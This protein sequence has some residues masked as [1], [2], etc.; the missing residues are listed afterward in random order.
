MRQTL[1]SLRARPGFALA[2]VTMLGLGIGIATAMFTIVDAL[3]LRP[4]PFH[5]PQELAFVYMGNA[6]G[7]RTTVAPA[8]LRAWRESP[9]FTGAEGANADTAVID[10][11]G[12]VATRGSARVT[13]GLFS[14][15]GNVRPI[16]GRLFDPGEGRAGSDD[17]VVVSEDLWRSLYGA[18]PGIINQRVTIDNES[19]LVVG[20]LPADF[21]FPN[22][23]TVIWRPIDYDAPPAGREADWPRAYVRFAP[24]LPRDEAIR[25]AATAAHDADAAAAKLV[26]RVSPMAGLRLD[27]YS[28]RAV[29]L[30]A[31]AVALVFLVLC[32]NVCSLLLS[33]LTDA[34]REFSIRA[35]LGASQ[36]TLIRQAL[37]ESTVLGASGAVVGAGI[38]WAA[39]ALA[40]TY[41]PESFVLQTLNPL[42]LDRRALVAASVAGISATLA[43]GLIPAWI[44][45]RVDSGDSLR[46]VGRSGT[47][48]RASSGIT[49]ALLVSEIA[50]A[51]TLLTAATLLVRSFANL[52]GV[53]RGVDSSRV[54]TATMTLPPSAF[55]DA[56]SRA[57]IA[58]SLDQRMRDLPGVRQVVWSFGLPPS[59]GG[60]STREWLA[61][62]GGSPGVT[63]TVNTY[64][65]TADFFPMYGIPIIMGRAFQPSD[66]ANQVIVGER[67]ARALWGTRNPVGSTFTYARSENSPTA[68]PPTVYEVIGLAREQA[69]PTLEARL[70]RPEFYLPF[71]N[72]G[73]YAMMS[74]GCGATCPDPAQLRHALSTSHP[75]IRVNN[76][77][78]LDSA[79]AEHLARP[80]AAAVLAFAF[81][82][83]AVVAAAGGLFSVLS[84][85]VG[86]RRRE[87]GIRAAVG[88]SPRQLGQVVLREGLLITFAGIA[89]GSIGSVALGRALS[90]L[91]YGVAPSDPVS[92]AL[93]IAVLVLTALAAGWRPARQAIRT[94]PVV[95]L[96]EE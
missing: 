73:G 8:V 69:L 29:P 35:A 45:T 30:L 42:D 93:V 86:R 40:R 15:L 12:S 7:G 83:I 89:M 2:A 17:R 58:A 78:T 33:R 48:S 84:Y 95:L 34:G 23:E 74:V 26:P 53:E 96:R 24:N 3:L 66:A 90:A 46:G 36:A 67:F 47:D 52:S 14:L 43:S 54:V 19:L 22:A 64:N 11:G 55:P 10:T 57:A 92:W 41:L 13:P 76:V 75:A 21:R 85:A 91:Q 39:V 16:R 68:P 71:G 44:G 6:N 5:A 70:D 25:L 32:A 80:R 27:D 1:R 77:G 72:I 59:D 61:D 20:I 60:F 31:G 94:D 9:A 18:D 4:V 88:A 63:M 65:V 37:V 82:A 79:F 50:L 38:A 81:A 87:F 51:C 62:Q 49:R 28:R 56:A